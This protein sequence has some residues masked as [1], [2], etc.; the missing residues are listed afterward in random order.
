MATVTEPCSG[1]D[2]A[3][4]PLGMFSEDVRYAEPCAWRAGA[5]GDKLLA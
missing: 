4:G 5:L 1:L 2:A 3:G